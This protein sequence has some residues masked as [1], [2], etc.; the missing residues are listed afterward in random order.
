MT[1]CALEGTYLVM[2][3]LRSYVNPEQT[4]DFVQKHSGW[5]WITVNGSARHIKDSSA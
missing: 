3:D 2:I 4:L 1:V 5:L